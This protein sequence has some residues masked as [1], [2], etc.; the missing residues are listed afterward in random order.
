MSTPKYVILANR[1]HPLYNELKETGHTFYDL[2]KDDP[3]EGKEA[4]YREADL[5][6]DFTLL[7]R[8]K[9]EELLRILA[10]QMKA[11]VVS[12]LTCLWGDFFIE[13]FPQIQGAMA[14]AFWAPTQKREVVAKD[15]EV[16]K[17]VSTLLKE[18]GLEA[19]EVSQPGHGFIY[20][21]T[22]SLLINEACLALED[23][24]ASAK[25]LDT[26]MK[27]GVNY[28]LGLVEWKEK[29]GAKAVLMLL[30]DL[31]H[32]TKDDR[33]RASVSLRKEAHLDSDKVQA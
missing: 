16:F 20:P 8:D 1:D 24:L 7:E 13:K 11:P 22:V 4:R 26:A 9:K 31:H 10:I 17:G 32:V 33:Y 5:V 28:P 30:D 3:F 14:T 12:D 23:K 21:R 2:H 29:I 19:K 27:F 6:F 15:T 25:D 18:V